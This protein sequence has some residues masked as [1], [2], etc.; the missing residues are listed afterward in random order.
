M[1]QEVCE[2]ELIDT[3]LLLNDEFNL[4][5][6]YAERRAAKTNTTLGVDHPWLGEMDDDEDTSDDDDSDSGDEDSDDEDSDGDEPAVSVLGNNKWDP[7]GS[8]GSPGASSLTCGDTTDEIEDEWDLTAPPN[9]PCM[10]CD[11]YA[12]ISVVGAIVSGSEGEHGAAWWDNIVSILDNHSVVNTQS[13]NMRNIVEWQNGIRKWETH[14]DFT[15]LQVAGVQIPRGSLAALQRNATIPK[16]F[17]RTVPKPVV[18]VVHLNGHPAR[19]LLDSG[20]LGDFVS[21]ALAD[22]LKLTKVEL[23]KPLALQLA[24][25]GSHSKV[26]WG[27]KTELKYQRIK[28][29]RYFDV[30]NLSNY[31]LILG[32]PWLFQHKVTVGLNPARVVVGSDDP[33]LIE[34][35][36]VMRIASRAMELLEENLEE[37]R[38]MLTEY[39]RDICKELDETDLPPF[40]A[41][42]HEI[43]LIDEH[44]IYPWRPSRCPEVFRGQWT[45]KK[46][47][48]LKSG[49]W[50]VSSARN[51]VPMMFIAKPGRKI[52]NV[53]ELRTVVDLRARNANTVKMS[54]PLPDIDGVLQRVAN[55]KY[56]SLLDLKNAYEQIRIIP[57]HVGRSA[58]TTPDGNM[59]SLVVQ[60]GDCNAPATYQALMNH[61]FS[62][63]IGRF[64]DVYLDDIIVYSDTFKDHMSH[65][66]IVV[67]ILRREKLYLSL[68]KLN[69]FQ[70]ELK[71]LGRIVGD[72]GIRMDPAKVESVLTWKTPTNRD[73]LRGFLGSVGYLADDLACVRIPMG[74]LHGL[75]GDAVP[76]RWEYTHQRAFE[77]IKNIV[78]QQQHS[79]RVPVKYGALAEVE[80]VFLITDGCAT[81]VAGVVAQGSD[82]KTAKVAAFFSA[83]LNSAQQNYPVHEIEMLAGVETMLRHRDVLQGTY[84]KWITD[85]KGLIHLVHQKDLS[86]R[87]A[88]WME[89]ISEFDFEVVYVPGVE[90]VL[91]DALSRMYSNDAPGT[92]RARS[93]YTYHDV[94]SNDALLSHGIS[95]PVFAG[96]EA[97][98]VVPRAP[99]AET[100][101]PETSREFATRMRDHFVLKGPREQM[102]GGNGSKKLT[103]KIPAQKKP[104]I[105]IPARGDRPLVDVE[106]E[107][108]SQEQDDDS[109]DQLPD[110]DGLPHEEQGPDTSLVGVIS[111]GRDGLD[112]LAVLKDKY[113]QD[114]F[115]KTI[116]DK[117]K[118]YRNF[119]VDNGLVYVKLQDRKLLCIPKIIVDGRNVRE[120]VI[121]EAHS[122]LAHLGVA[123]TLAYLRDHVWWKQMAADTVTYCST[124]MTC[125]RSKPATQK[126]YGLLNPLEIPS[127]PW[128]SIGVDFVGPLPESRNRD[129]TFNSITVVI[130]LLTAMVHLIPSC[131]D[132]KAPQVAEMMFDH[133][134]KH[135]GLP[136]SIVS[137]RDVLFTSTFWRHLH[138]LV[139]T[140]LKMSSAYHPQTDGSTE[141]AN[142]TVT[143]MLRQCIDP[144]QKSW[145]SKLSAI[146]FAINS[147]RSASTGYAPFFLNTGR[148]PR[149][150]IWDSAKQDEYPGVRNFALQHKLALIAAHDSILAARVKE[151]RNANRKR[152]LVPFTTDELVYLSTKN[153]TFPK[154]LARKLIPKFIGPYKIVRDFGNQSF[155]ID[156]PP[157]L[158]Q[159][160]VHDVFHT[161]LLRP[162]IP[163]DDRLFPGRLDT[164][165]GNADGT[166]GEWA[167]DSIITHVGVRRD[168]NFQILWK[169]GDKTWLPYDH[170]S[171]L[172]ALLGYFELLGIEKIAD[173]PEGSGQPLQDDPQTYIGGLDLPRASRYKEHTSFVRPRP[174]PPFQPLNSHH[175]QHKNVQPNTPLQQS[176]TSR[177]SHHRMCQPFIFPHEPV[178]QPKSRDARRPAPRVSSVR[179]SA[180]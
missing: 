143:Q 72:H 89:K 155:Q 134:Y 47:V 98:T 20:S 13:R 94:I 48:Y 126:P 2:D 17:T 43:P 21:T 80:Q 18:V 51:T 63:Y 132:Y 86:G 168:A 83:K 28:E 105:K 26:N 108:P 6:W 175:R 39:A 32:T 53:P 102:E 164:Q 147:A 1:D 177:R 137:D 142:K 152:Q 97:A 141:R 127:Y 90:N 88:R 19:A 81:G 161:A 66:R 3:N 91:A 129:G 172:N 140:K 79:R 34:G 70:S 123:K 151:I 87:Q 159:R 85:H 166:D 106:S 150:M 174:F 69:F 36:D 37:G 58:V 8:P 111:G 149:S 169:S 124:C 130:C 45:E 118:D 44:K 15:T 144:K 120:I 116:L 25:Q 148:M 121:A 156:L 158:R 60:M 103:I 104:T 24:V 73:L 154:G 180:T 176:A 40:R 163:N 146:E 12:S 139:G 59:V 101:R 41:I 65:V 46:D 52:D 61:I 136:K 171:H 74:V 92:V 96:M 167:V 76:F 22:Q 77:D 11:E 128:E 71:L 9:S 64:L 114:T 68:K 14:C 119:E 42:N 78:D 4:P 113:G 10:E 117:L 170:V 179:P 16:D 30:A 38:K 162:H 153:I 133:V 145:V 122:L 165:L 31:D 115:F 178:N 57:E 75:T 7:P 173:L 160:G 55:A 99:G 109:Q 112:L 67:D 23:K 138:E 56:R 93:E 54:S 82:W 62:S 110:G 157:H 107:K 125:R 100:G 33:L 95:M 135:H 84:F 35:D 29:Q 131:E 27:V 50:K 5:E 49:R